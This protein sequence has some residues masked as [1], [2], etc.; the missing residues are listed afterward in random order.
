MRQYQGDTSSSEDMLLRVK[1]TLLL[2]YK[3]CKENQSF[4]TNVRYTQSMRSDYEHMFQTM[5]FGN[6]M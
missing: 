5:F 6:T 1:G 3:K 2:C 4:E